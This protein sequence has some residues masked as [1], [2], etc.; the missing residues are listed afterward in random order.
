MCDDLWGAQ[1]AQVAC[2]QLGFTATG[3]QALQGSVTP[4]GIGHIWLDDVQCRGT[5]TRLIDCAYNELGSHNCGHN[6]DAGVNCPTGTSPPRKC[7]AYYIH[8]QRNHIRC[9]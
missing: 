9:F 5:E 4:D 8:E 6:E 7:V 2:R 3:A 1:D